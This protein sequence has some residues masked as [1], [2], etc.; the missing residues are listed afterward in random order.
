MRKTNKLLSILL[1]LVM[2]IGLLPTTAFAWTAPSLT[3]G[4]AAWNVQLSDEGVLTWNDMGSATYDIQVD[5]TAMG[6]TVTKIQGISGT[7]Y[8]LI[9]RFK[10]LKIENGTYYFY[11]KAND[12]DATSGDISFKYVSPEPKLSAPQNLRWDGTVAKWDSVAN[13]TGYAVMLYSDSGSLQLSKTTTETQYDWDT[14]VYN[15]GFWFEVVATGDNYRNSNA[16]EGPK[17]GTYSWTAPT[18]TGGKAAW[19]VTLSDDGMLRWNDMSSAT[20]DI[21]VDETEMGGTVTNIYNINT[22]AFN[23][24]NQLKDIKAENGIYYFSIKAN[25]TEE[26]SGDISFR[27]VSPE[28]KL[29]APQNLRWEGTVAKWDSV[30]GASEYKVILYTDSG[31]VQLNRTA[32]TTQ[33]DWESQATDGRWFEVVATADGYRDSNVAE[34]PK[35]IVVRY[36]IGAYPYDASVSQTQAGG[37]VYLTTDEGSDGWSSDGYIKKATEGTTVTLNANP[38]VGY[39]FVEWR[40]GTAGATISTEANYQ[41]TASEDKYLYAVFETISSTT[42]E[43]ELGIFDITYTA[44]DGGTVSIQANKGYSVSGSGVIGSATENTAVTITAVPKAGYEFVAWKLW[45]PHNAT[46]FSTNATYTFNAT[47]E[48]FIYAVFQETQQQ[49]PTYEINCVAHNLSSNE[50]GGT[51]QLETDKGGTGYAT[52]QQ[53]YATENTTVKV[54]A[55]AEEDYEFVEWRKGSP[56]DANS[57]V[58]T[59]AYYEFTATEAVW[60]YAVFQ[61]TPTCTIDCSVFDITNGINNGQSGVGGTVSIQTDKGSVEGATPIPIQATRNSSV[62]VNAVAAQG[63]EFIGWKKSSPYV[64][65]NLS[66][67][68][69]YTFT[70]NEYLYLYAVFQETANVPTYTVSFEANGGTGTMADVNDVSGDYI[71]PANGFTPPANKQFKAWSVGGDEKAAGATITVNANT[72][73]TAIWEDIPALT[74]TVTITGDAKYGSTLTA[75]VE[76]SNNTGELHYQWVRDA[77]NIITGAN[78]QTYTILLENNINSTLKCIVTSSVQT[79]SIVSAP[80]ALVTKGDNLAVPTGLAGVAPTTLG[81]YDC[82]ITGTTTAMEWSKYSDFHSTEGACSDGQTQ[83][84][85]PGTYYV[86]YRQTSTYNAGINY[87]TVVVPDFGGAATYTVSFAANGG[88]G[89][90]ADVTNVSGDYVLPAN[91]FTPPVNKQFK[92][93]SVG[94]DEKAVGATINVTANTTVTA[95]WEDIPV[96]T[97]TVTFDANGGSVTPANATTEATGKLA[98]LPTPTRSGSYTF[99]GWYTASSGGAQVTVDKVYTENTTIYAQWNY[100]GSTGGGGGVSKYTIKFETNGGTTVANKSVTRNAKL[101]EPTAPTKDGFKFDGWYTD[102]ELKTAYDFDTKVTKSFTLYAKWTEIEKEPENDNPVDTDK[103]EN[104]FTD[105]KEN[106]WYYADV[107]YAVENG[108]FNGTSATAFAPNGI[109]TRAMMVTVLYR[110]EGEPAVN[111]SIPF[112]DVDMGAYYANAVI[113]A[114]Q[115]GI[116]NG[117]SETEFAPNDNITREQIAAIMHRYAQYKGYDVS[118]GENTNILSYDDFDSISEYAIASMQYACGS[119]LMKGKTASTLNPKDNA[120]RAEIAAILHRFIEANK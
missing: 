114:K 82:Y 81:G 31:S 57:V 1:S 65:E 48:L 46:A 111:K 44:T 3:G 95:V 47:E 50:T 7:S 28:T 26:T 16:A 117:V 104:P 102:K 92:A 23:L 29:A 10:E 76:N 35:Y 13:A 58:S 4:N 19:N 74:G 75:T 101:A 15:D 33:Y 61:H 54:R 71:L 78:E 8:N 30:D 116:V 100:T 91:G 53:Q 24:I 64:Q 32:T 113:W 5:E 105:V 67:S 115:N 112:A 60:I 83:V 109:I 36:S 90:M 37:Q 62:T 87:A 66:T 88:T 51:V 99:K 22:N 72:T 56:T 11:I 73:V 14:N 49:T 40:Q 2:L 38:A 59:E 79:G 20:Y 97:Y 110:A 96:T 6:G 55:R 21:Y 80:T 17:Y 43:I 45:T 9:N 70:I 98:T 52:S 27:Y 85:H 106:D 108:L 103:W 120:T 118:V 25:D 68:P 94:G 42:Y 39:K 107:E 63:Y 89:T 119:G 41:F 84:Y 34:S 86:R 93:W 77:S 18:L 12:T 69:T